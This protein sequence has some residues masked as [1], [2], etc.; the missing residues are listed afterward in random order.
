MRNTIIMMARGIGLC[1]VDTLLVDDGSDAISPTEAVSFLRLQVRR[2]GDTHTRVQARKH[3]SFE[4]RCC[5]GAG[6][7]AHSDW[8]PRE[9]SMQRA[10]S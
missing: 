3:M 1:G 9:G 8:G 10:P 4:W 7:E 6:L 5:R 2:R